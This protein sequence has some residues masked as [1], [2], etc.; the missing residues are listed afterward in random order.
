M[1]RD[2][3]S[4]F[5]AVEALRPHLRK[6]S[7]QSVPDPGCSE[8][9][10]ERHF[11][12]DRHEKEVPPCSMDFAI[13]SE[14]VK[15]A[16]DTPFP[17]IGFTYEIKKLRNLRAIC[18]QNRANLYRGYHSSPRLKPGSRIPSRNTEQNGSLPFAIRTRIGEDET[19]RNGQEKQ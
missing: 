7:S 4:H 8:R 16:N 15:S 11:Y 3:S 14:A 2:D 5:E 13:Q 10:K 12:F 9:S 19:C 6:N 18:D 1:L 17:G